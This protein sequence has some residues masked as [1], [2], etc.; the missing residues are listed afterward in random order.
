MAEPARPAS[1]SVVLP[2]FNRLQYLP[3]TVASVFGQ[4][5]SDWELLIADDGSDADTRR[6]LA[7]LED[8]LKV[9]VLRLPHTGIPA[10]SRNA[11]LREATGEYVAFL[12][13]DD[14]WAPTK[15]QTQFESL[16]AH[17]ACGWSYTGFALING[18]GAPLAARPAPRSAPGS[19]W[20]VDELLAERIVIVTPSVMARRELLA[21]AGGFNETLRVGED[22]ELWV[23]LALCSQ[24]DFVD[25]SLTLVRRHEAH[26]F[27]DVTCL[28]NFLSALEIVRRSGISDRQ[29]ELVNERRATVCARLAH[30]HARKRDGARSA[31]TLLQ[32][33]PFAWRYPRWWRQAASA[34]V[35]AYWPA[36]VSRADGGDRPVIP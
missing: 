1:I 16:R 13:S 33:I 4:T 28:E 27:D 18:T 10:A 9:R 3:D 35:R 22:Y 21:K 17:P 29:R 20:I 36:T 7:T 12:D 32:G 26:S 25:N 15:L 19:G 30:A 6:Y 23:R 5:T 14:L 11:A 2:T 34:L 24:A 8:G 31:R